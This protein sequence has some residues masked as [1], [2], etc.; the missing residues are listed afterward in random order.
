MGLTPVALEFF[1]MSCILWAAD[2]SMRT[3]PLRCL[4]ILSPLQHRLCSINSSLGSLGPGLL[5]CLTFGFFAMFRQSNLAP[6]S[7]SQLDLTRHTCRGHIFMAP[8]GLQILVHWSKT[9][10]SIG[11]APVL[12]IPEVQGQPSDKDAAY[13]LLLAS[14]PTTLADQPL[15]T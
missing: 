1:Q 6:P 10:Q 12:S 13:L 11:I 2:I 14:S 5:V 9:H 8:P 3:Q 7:A 4:L 15:L